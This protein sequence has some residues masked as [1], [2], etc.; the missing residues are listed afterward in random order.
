MNTTQTPDSEHKNSDI[1]LHVNRI[2]ASGILARSS[3]LNR[4]FEFLY[5]CHLNGTTPK[6]VEIAVEGLGRSDSFDVT[7]DAVVRVYVHKLRR[8][9][10]DYY[11]HEGKNLASRLNVP[12][13]E[14][15]LTLESVAL[16]STALP[17][18]SS[19][20]RHL[21]Y[22][23]VSV[24]MVSL[25]LNLLQILWAP[26]RFPFSHESR[27]RSAPLWQPLFADDRPIVVVLGNYYIYAETDGGEAVKRLVREFDLNSPMELSNYLQLYPNQA[28]RKFD[29]GLS[30]LPT[31]VGYALNKLSPILNSSGKQVKVIL[32]SELTPETLLN[33][34][35]VYIG[36][37]SGLGMLSD[38]VYE[39]SGFH[40]GSGYD[41]LINNATGQQYLSGSG[42]PNERGG[43]PNQLAYLSS[44]VGPTG[45]HIITVAGFRDAGLKELSDVV[46]SEAGV[47]DLAKRHL[48]VSFEAIYQVAGFG[49]ATA[50]AKLL[51]MHIL[52]PAVVS[53]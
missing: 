49:Q 51:T 46:S 23:L 6:E 10:D 39:N 11:Q 13:G 35:I 15:R 30:Y 50:P 27:I 43:N 4:L 14:Y 34:N 48:D 28:E 19:R 47:T 44:M 52:K 45:N 5:A 18:I 2:R 8:K 1:D 26:L 24:L 38:I 36:H 29:V 33:T 32:A 22:A 40:V 20:Q 42:N 53:H 3:H 7:Q 37:L 41:E 21:V 25:L 17:S 12:K 16:D 31:S 9:L